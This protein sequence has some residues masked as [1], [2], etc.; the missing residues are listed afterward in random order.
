MNGNIGG[1]NRP[2]HGGP[3]KQW[4]SVGKHYG[5]VIRIMQRLAHQQKG[6]EQTWRTGQAPTATAWARDNGGQDRLVVFRV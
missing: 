5:D 2:G 4:K 6:E 3:Y 1:D